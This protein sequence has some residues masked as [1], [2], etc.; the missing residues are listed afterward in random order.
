MKL[1]E[2]IQ[3]IERLRATGVHLLTEVVIEDGSSS[4]DVG[5]IVY[6]RGRVV[7][8]TAYGADLGAVVAQ[9]EDKP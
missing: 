1:K 6:D 7:I 3:Q 9:T 4:V 2:L 8:K 5:P